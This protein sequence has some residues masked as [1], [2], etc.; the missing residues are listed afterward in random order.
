MIDCKGNWLAEPVFEEIDCEFHD[1]LFA[2]FSESPWDNDDAPM[3]I[4]DTKQKRVL[5]EPQFTDVSFMDDGYIEVEAYD[6]TL[7]RTVT[8]LIDRNGREKFHSEYS[9]IYTWTDPYEVVIRD[10]DGASR[11]GLI[12]KDGNVLL[13][14][15]FNAAWDGISYEH[16]FVIFEED[17]KKGLQDFDGNIILPAE[18]SEIYR[19]SGPLLIVCKGDGDKRKC[20][21]VT[22][23]GTTVLPIDYERISC[24]EGG[25]YVCSTGEHCEVFQ[26]IMN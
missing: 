17:K 20:G 15:K 8:R 12:D 16:K 4:Y 25:R 6:E 9:S 10:K 7:G 26:L 19:R 5:F 24:F 14:C 21:L 11:R 22:R 23:D 13:P 18:Y 2:F 1:G 3:G